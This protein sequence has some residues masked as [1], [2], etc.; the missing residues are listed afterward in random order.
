M[1]LGL[2]LG[3]ACERDACPQPTPQPIDAGALGDPCGA[4]ANCTSG[5]SCR[6]LYAVPGY[7]S[8]SFTQNACSTP[9]DA[10]CSGAARCVTLPSSIETCLPGCA[11]DDDCQV[12]ISAGACDAGHCERLQCVDDGGCPSGFHCEIPAIICCPRGAKCPFSG[13]VPGYCRRT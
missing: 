6:A 2:A 1:V 10:G 12:G 9:C 13:P 4:D 7:D 3:A 11:A 8:P 5:L